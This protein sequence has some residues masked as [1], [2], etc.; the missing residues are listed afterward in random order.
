MAWSSAQLLFLWIFRLG[1]FRDRPRQNG[2]ST[3]KE[4]DLTILTWFS[5]P[6]NWK[7]TVFTIQNGDFSPETRGFPWWK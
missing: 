4:W 3:I 6:K 7:L 1:N 5:H 2:E